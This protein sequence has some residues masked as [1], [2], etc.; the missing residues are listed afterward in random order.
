[1]LEIAAVA[2]AGI[3]TGTF[4]GLIPGIHPNTVI[5][6][7]FP[8][9]FSLNINLPVFTVFIAALSVSH[10]FHDF[11]P[12]IYLNAP[13]ADSAVASLPG[14]RKALE[15]EGPE[16]FQYTLDGGLLST[17][18]F[19]FSLP[20]FFLFLSDVYGLAS[21]LMPWILGFFLLFIL[22]S[23]WSKAAVAVTVFSGV[24]G[25]LAFN[26]SVNQNFVLMPVFSGLFA[27]PALL[28]LLKTGKDLPEQEKEPSPLNLKG[29]GTGFL[30]G[31]LAGTVPGVGAGVATSFLSPLI[32]NEKASLT[33][34][35][36]VN[37]ADIF[38]SLVALFI[39]GKARSGASVAVEALGSLDFSLL[40][41]AL[42]TSFFSAGLSFLLAQRVEAL[43]LKLLEWFNLQLIALPVLIV[44]FSVSLIFTGFI[45]VL[46]LLVS[47]LI[48]LLGWRNSC[49]MCCMNVL[50]TPA[51]LFYLGFGIFI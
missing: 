9:Y 33:G 8:F 35:G 49:R 16:A 47:A 48:G 1:M 31:I 42:G 41:L 29:G 50:I 20:F 27:A 2:L 26:T 43:F 12:A 34:L 45:G 19:T 44:L 32:D 22:L 21:A 28:E 11:L 7:L 36:A 30:A 37:T 23:N 10:T 3:M 25:V 18:F 13:S 46:I 40:V 6:S 15:G 4:T 38:M 5:F 24:L 39:I 51:L 14:A 17:V